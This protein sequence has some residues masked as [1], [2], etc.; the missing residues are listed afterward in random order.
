MILSFPPLAIIVSLSEHTAFIKELV[1]EF[2]IIEFDESE[3]LQ[4][5]T[6]PSL[7]A[8]T[9]VEPATVRSLTSDS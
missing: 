4:D 8:E 6:V 5:L 2:R 7:E 3:R 9:R 1:E